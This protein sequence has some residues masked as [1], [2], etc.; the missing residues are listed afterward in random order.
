MINRPSCAAGPRHDQ[1][2]QPIDEEEPQQ[3]SRQGPN[4]DKRSAQRAKH[5]SNSGVEEYLE[6]LRPLCRVDV[7]ALEP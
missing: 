7:F 5:R 2:Q 4:P 1:P 3:R 6:V